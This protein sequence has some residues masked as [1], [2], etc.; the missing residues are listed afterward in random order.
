MSSIHL[1]ASSRTVGELGWSVL[2]TSP[3][4]FPYRS[5]GQDRKVYLEPSRNAPGSA[6]GDQMKQASIYHGYLLY[7]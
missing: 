4:V 7:W 2:G 5:F 6:A 1:C 3:Q